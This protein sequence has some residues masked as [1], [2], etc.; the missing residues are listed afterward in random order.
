MLCG[1]M[2]ENQ[3]FTS[4]LVIQGHAKVLAVKNMKLDELVDNLKCFWEIDSMGKN[5]AKSETKDR[6]FWK[7]INFVNKR[8]QIQLPWDEN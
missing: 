5:Y 6:K 3:N 1:T 4:N 2:S 8:Y 7:D